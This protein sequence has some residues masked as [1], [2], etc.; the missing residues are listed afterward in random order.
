MSNLPFTLPACDQPATERVEVVSPDPAGDPWGSLDATVYACPAHRT[1]VVA[2][3]WRAELT[4]HEVTMA[5]DVKRTC[6]E[7]YI[8]PTGRMG[9]HR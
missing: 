5:P 4:A 3:I 2:S 1:D 8:F 9:G 7:S 6:G